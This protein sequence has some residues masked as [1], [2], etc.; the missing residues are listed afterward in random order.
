MTDNPYRYTGPLNPLEDKEV[1]VPRETEIDDITAGLLRGDYWAI[2]GPRQ[3]GKTTLLRQIVNRYPDAHYVYV[4]LGIAPP[5]ERQFYRWLIRLTGEQI[6][7]ESAAAGDEGWG[8]SSPL[9]QFRHFLKAL[10][11]TDEK[12]RIIFL[13][14]EIEK[15][16]FTGNLLLLWRGIWHERASHPEFIRYSMVVTS[17]IDLTALSSPATSPFNIAKN[18]YMRDFSDQ[19]SRRLIDRPF[20]QLHIKIEA[21]AKK[22]LL[23][24]VSGHPQLLQHAGHIMV[25]IALKSK[26]RLTR[27]D[28]EETINLLLLTNSA[29]ELLR[30]DVRVNEPLR[31]LIREILTGAKKKFHPYKEFSTSG[32][33][34]IVP[35]KDGLCA[36]RNRV[37]DRF[38]RDLFEMSGEVPSVGKPGEHEP[39]TLPYG[40]GSYEDIRESR[41]Y[42]VDKTR[43]LGMI[44]E[45]GTYLVFIR[46][47]RFGKTLL[48]S[49]METYYDVNKAEAFDRYFSG[50]HIHNQ[51]TPER[52]SYLIL[53]FDFS[54]IKSS[55]DQVEDSFYHHVFTQAKI[56]ISKYH[57]LLKVDPGR[58]LEELAVRKNASDL[59]SS[60]LALCRIADREVYLIIDEYDNFANTILSTAGS[61]PYE[62]L[63]HGE[64]FFREFFKVIKSGTSGTDIPVKRLFITGVSPLTLDDVTSGFNIG[65]NISIDENFNEMMGFREQEV[66]DMI[67]YYRKAGKIHHETGHLLEVMSRWYNHY[68]FSRETTVEVFNPT[69]VLYF[70][71]EYF[72]NHRLPDELFDRNVRIDYPKL[73][74]LVMVDKRDRPETNGNFS[75]L[76]TVIEKGFVTSKLEKSFPLKHLGKPEN[77]SSLLFYFGLLTIDG[78]DVEREDKLILK[79]PNESIRKL[80]YEYIREAYMETELFSLNHEKYSELM[81]NMAYRGEW[82]PLFAYISQQMQSSLGLRDLISGEKFIQ[83]FLTAY[84]GWSDLY[85]ICSETE[86]NKGYADLL[87]EPFLA[88]YEGVRYAYLIE[89]K[90]IK[91]SDSKSKQL[92]DRLKT[93][94]KEQLKRYSLDEKLR[95][96][97]ERTTLIKLALVFAGHELVYIEKV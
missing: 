17:S 79:I 13:F 85:S 10:R 81:E 32:A 8:E 46:P 43:Y 20:Q 7:S 2:I 25:G 80:F 88:K 39:K 89:I 21:E 28:I 31:Q 30:R 70:L 74:H 97:L 83:G 96:R 3:S 29:I 11:P 65:E 16:S 61:R 36:I 84:L 42:Y 24:L 12:E 49:M 34:C 82:R 94:A 18:F 69:L 15:F 56:F 38:L 33:G 59:L 47:R 93:E 9:Y 60:L 86:L 55:V 26:R 73:R 14:D 22:R 64:G 63:T 44:E 27:K 41:H 52:N 68:R 90:Y 1:C 45:A 57:Q 53:K 4:N 62:D 50:T 91:S 5:D 76:R 37:F 72:K 35:D 67:E 40:V 23:S 19:E 54:Q 66:I 6:P 75:R 77:F 58:S 92:P 71:K 95:K 48:I 51:P 87:M 78:T